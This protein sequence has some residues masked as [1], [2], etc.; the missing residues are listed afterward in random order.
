[1]NECKILVIIIVGINI[2]APVTVSGALH[3]LPHSNSKALTCEHCYAY[4]AE[5]TKAQG[6]YAT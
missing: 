2:F 3:R 5:G 4:F 6:A 1:M